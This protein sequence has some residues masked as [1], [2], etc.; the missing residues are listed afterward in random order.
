MTETVRKHKAYR[1][2]TDAANA[3]WDKISF[4]THGS[5]VE[6]DDGTTAE[7]VKALAED[8]VN[9]TNDVTSQIVNSYSSVPNSAALYNAYEELSEKAG[10]I[11]KTQSQYD[12]LPIAE[13]TDPSKY[14]CI[15][16]Q[17]LS[18]AP[19]DDDSISNG[20]VW[21]AQK[22]GNELA[23]RDSDISDIQNDITTL[24]SKSLK[25][26]NTHTGVVAITNTG[27][28]DM[29]Y[30]TLSIQAPADATMAVSVCW[31]SSY[32]AISIDV[33][34]NIVNGNFQVHL[35]SSKALTTQDRDI[36]IFYI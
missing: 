10:I 31:F 27:T 34:S 23:A 14:Y 19:L 2:C 9:W 11:A 15:T 1:L 22:I 28:N 29:Y 24:N 3:L 33:S 36:R 8:A 16:D 20:K 7:D 21:S 13:K 17:T 32:N 35:V 25:Y 30:A 18:G 4:W 26:F 12:A 5:D 6:F